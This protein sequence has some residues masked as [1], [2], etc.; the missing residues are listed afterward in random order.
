VDERDRILLFAPFSRV[1][2]GDLGIGLAV[3][4]AIVEAHGG[5]IVAERPTSGARFRV[6]LPAEAAALEALG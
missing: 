6:V 4:R 5:R 2:C 3:T 1:R